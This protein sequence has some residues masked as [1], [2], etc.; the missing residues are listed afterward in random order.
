LKDSLTIYGGNIA[1]SVTA[2]YDVEEDTL[3]DLYAAVG[4]TNFTNFILLIEN[5][6]I[7]PIPP[8]PPDPVIQTKADMLFLGLGAIFGLLIGIGM[9]VCAYYLYS[10]NKKSKEQ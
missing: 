9:G 1:T 3:Q 4:L 6:E 2:Y 8:L 5:D 10:Y 7:P